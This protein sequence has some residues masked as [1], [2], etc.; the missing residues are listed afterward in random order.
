MTIQHS[1]TPTQSCPTVSTGST[2]STTHHEPLVDPAQGRRVGSRLDLLAQT[3]EH[4]IHI[5]RQ[6]R[7]H[8]KDV[9][10][11]LGRRRLRSGWHPVVFRQL[12]E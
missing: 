9:G 12:E 6:E 8:L 1:R 5:R 7:D 11:R 2:G 3:N 10:A 4:R